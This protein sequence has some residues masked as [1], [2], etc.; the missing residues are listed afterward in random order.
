MRAPLAKASNACRPWPPGT[1]RPSIPRERTALAWTDAVTRVSETHVS[2]AL[3]AEVRQ[4]FSEQ[5]LVDLRLTLAA[6]N[7]WNRLAISF[8]PEVG[9][10][11][12]APALPARSAHPANA[13]PF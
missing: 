8:R 3:F 5:E 13:P 7:G 6:I 12:R 9:S 10:D 1:R 11:Q 2:D 4:H